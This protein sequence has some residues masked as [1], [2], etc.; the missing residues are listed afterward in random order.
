M[1]R[2]QQV[3]GKMFLELSE[4]DVKDLFPKLG[5]RKAVR[6]FLEECQRAAAVSC[7]CLVPCIT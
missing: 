5:H 3:S 6:M 4:K 2:D 7:S 1:L